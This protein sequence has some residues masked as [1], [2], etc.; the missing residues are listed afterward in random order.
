MNYNKLILAGNLVRDPE[1]KGSCVVFTIAVNE[2]A[3]GE[4]K[5][6]FMRCVAFQKTGELVMSYVTKGQN[7][8]V[9]GRLVSEEYE[10]DGQKRISYSL[11]ANSVQFGK[12]NETGAPGDSYAREGGWANSG[13]T[14]PLPQETAPANHDGGQ[15]DEAEDDLPF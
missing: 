9:E 12:K 1:D 2:R 3:K 4:D 5:T 13:R 10:K 11:L 7:V 15:T 6:L 8:L 14:R